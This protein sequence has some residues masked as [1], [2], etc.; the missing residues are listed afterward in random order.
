MQQTWRAFLRHGDEDIL[1][2]ADFLFLASQM[3]TNVSSPVGKF[4]NKFSSFSEHYS[5]SEVTNKW[6]YFCCTVSCQQVK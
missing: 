1:Q 5:K 6:F 4:L 2:C 3:Y